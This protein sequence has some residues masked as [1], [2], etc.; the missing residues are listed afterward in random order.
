MNGGEAKPL[1][2]AVGSLA[3]RL[4]MSAGP[5][6][7]WRWAWAGPL[8]VLALAAPWLVA[9]LSG[10]RFLLHLAITFFVWSVVT[11]S[12]NLILGI[13]GIYS[14][15]QMALYAVG[16]WTTGV[17]ALHFNW[18]PLVS[19]WTAPLAAVIAALIIG[20]PTLR[21]RGVYVV[22][23]TLSFHELLRNFVQNGPQMISAG[24][25]G[26]L[27]VPKFP[28]VDWWQG[29]Y[30]MVLFYYAGLAMFLVTTYCVWRV[31]YSPIGMAFTAL[32]DSEAYAVSRGVN[33][34]RL[35]LFLFAISAFFTGLAGGFMT[36]YQGTI[37]PS[38]LNLGTMVNLLAM[39]V[40]GGWGTFSGPIIGAAVLIILT[41][42][43]ERLGPYRNL[44]LGVALA[45]LAVLA[46]Q[47][48]LSLVQKA[49]QRPRSQ[50]S[51]ISKVHR[52]G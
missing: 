35:R 45:A 24:G 25:Y 31:I 12:W 30:E 26:L 11:Q 52:G 18:H 23:L 44:A 42:W 22:L 17:L 49:I 50:G 16:G 32:R 9:S 33:P 10:G 4:D 37:S 34:F 48:L 36:H 43:M 8:L 27:Y 51:G 40:I 29:R 6:A 5:W 7:R 3:S 1:Q 20:L 28:F 39:I 21:L 38:I 41:E 14:F 19:I 13:S 47:G 46:S 15:G 2:T